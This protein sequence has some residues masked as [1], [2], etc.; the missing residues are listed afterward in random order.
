M[1]TAPVKEAPAVY[2]SGKFLLVNQI[3]FTV[4]L[5]PQKFMAAPRKLWRTSAWL[6][7]ATHIYVNLCVFSYIQ[8]I[9]KIRDTKTLIILKAQRD[10]STAGGVSTV[11][12]SYSKDCI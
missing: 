1:G 11:S 6:R 10:R 2:G 7:T 5:S 8:S 12:H 9:Y 4:R 3:G